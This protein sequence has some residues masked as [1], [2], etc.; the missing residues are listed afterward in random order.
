MSK[1]ETMF[2]FIDTGTHWGWFRIVPTE[3]GWDIVIPEDVTL[4]EAAQKFIDTVNGMLGRSNG[5]Q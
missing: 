5:Q 1:E 4:T 3:T 2:T